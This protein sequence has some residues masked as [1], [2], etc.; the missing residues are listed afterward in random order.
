MESGGDWYEFLGTCVMSW[1]YL[2]SRDN[3]GK[4]LAGWGAELRVESFFYS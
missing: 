3:L 1:S 2:P 4:A